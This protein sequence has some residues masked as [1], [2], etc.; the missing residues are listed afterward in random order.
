MSEE[1]EM[2]GKIMPYLAQSLDHLARVPYRFDQ[3][4]FDLYSGRTR[5]PLVMTVFS[6]G[7]PMERIYPARRECLAGELSKMLDAVDEKQEA[8]GGTFDYVVAVHP[9][10]V[11]ETGWGTERKKFH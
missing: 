1:T 8:F 3:V 4:K 6:G 10:I 2:G 7:H 11:E 5:Q 9:A